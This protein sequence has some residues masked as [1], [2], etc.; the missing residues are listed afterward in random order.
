[1]SDVYAALRAS[2]DRLAGLAGGLTPDR[3]TGRAYPA[4]WSIAQVFS[5]LGSGAEIM[6]LSVDAALTGAPAPGREANPPIWDRWNAKE[7]GAQVTEGVESDRG[8][9]TR[10]E[11]LDE[12]QRAQLRFGSFLGEVDAET[13]ARL[14]L[15]EHAVHTW[16]IAVALDPSAPIG[17]ETVDLVLD[18]IGRVVGFAGK[19]PG[20]DA[21]VRVTTTDPDRTFTLTMGERASLQAGSSAPASASMTLPAE[22]FIRLVYGR[23]DA[24]HTPPV[25]VSGIDLDDLRRAFPGF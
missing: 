11:S 24:A 23:L 22:A 7:P 2:H 16:D 13:L 5:H 21:V 18:G 19:S 15:G 4:Q 17:P 1:M 9:V 12:R 10:F 6:A 14:R 3:A 25:T 8:L 20:L